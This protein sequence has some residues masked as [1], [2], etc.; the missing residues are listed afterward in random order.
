VELL[1]IEIPKSFRDVPV[2]IFDVYANYKGISETV[3]SLIVNEPSLW[4]NKHDPTLE[5]LF[6]LCESYK[7]III[8]YEREKKHGRRNYK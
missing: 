5:S 3:D 6:A 2:Y 1:S 7:K 4:E 8:D